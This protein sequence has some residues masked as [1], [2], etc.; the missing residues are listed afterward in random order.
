MRVRSPVTPTH[1]KAGRRKFD[2]RLCAF[3]RVATPLPSVLEV[4][5]AI[6]FFQLP[7]RS[8][9]HCELVSLPFPPGEGRASLNRRLFLLH[10]VV[11]KISHKSSRSLQ[12]SCG[13]ISNRS[14]IHVSW[15]V[16]SDLSM[17]TKRSSVRYI[18]TRPHAK[19]SC[20]A[21]PRDFEGCTSFS[22]NPL[23][24]SLCGVQE[25]LYPFRHILV[26]FSN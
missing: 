17:W 6:D 2:L 13:L 9:D 19:H 11:T 10:V 18:S 23:P 7:K 22:D 24:C 8:E 1:I 4:L 16:H 12:A 14:K 21:L 25:F 15:R 5:E 20:L 26:H 3:L